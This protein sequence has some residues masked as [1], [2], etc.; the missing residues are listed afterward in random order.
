MFFRSGRDVLGRTFFVYGNSE[1]GLRITRPD[2][3]KSSNPIS[4]PNTW[5]AWVLVGSIFRIDD[6]EGAVPFAGTYDL[7]LFIQRVD[8]PDMGAG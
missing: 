4:T 1:Q 6:V 2:L 8:G 3:K 7:A 5:W